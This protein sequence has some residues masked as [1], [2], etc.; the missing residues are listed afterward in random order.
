MADEITLDS[1]A[2][3]S[4]RE[5]SA[6]EEKKQEIAKITREVEKIT[7]VERER[8]DE[9]KKSI[10]LTD[11]QMSEQF[12]VGAQKN[13]AAFSE[14]ILGQIKSKDAGYVGD[15]LTNL[16]VTVKN[17]DIDEDDGNFFKKLPF[18]KQISN[19]AEKK[20][21][22]Y[23]TVE[24]QIDKIESE[25]DKARMGLLKDIGMLD[26]LYKQNVEYFNELQ[27]Y[28]L[29]GEEKIQELKTET[30]PR[31]REEAMKSDDA[32]STQ[33]VS[34]F[35][36]TVNRFEKKVHD[37][38]LSKTLAIQT[39]PQIK[40]IQNNDK[41]LVDKIQTAILNT[42]PLWK[43]QI[44]ISLA[45]DK[46]RAGV[47]MQ[48]SVSDTTNELLRK[49][50]EMLKSNTIE[51]AKE[52]ERGI[53]EI[54]TLKKVNDDLITTIDETLRI[55]KE[56]QARRLAAEQE[57]LKIEDTL[58]QSL[59]KSIDQG[60]TYERVQEPK[61]EG[62]RSYQNPVRD[63]NEDSHIESLLNKKVVDADIIEEE[64]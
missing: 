38:K 36:N 9:I 1:L 27:L 16:M 18:V 22:R 17:A 5:Q 44:V 11:S 64:K 28:I 25:L 41:A 6:Q 12:G 31:L 42:V 58:K 26:N 57:L 61:V 53:V 52:S 49:N 60:K 40:L 23:S 35:E 32:M 54:D 2:R 48:K 19:S 10:N 63:S 34:D 4:A 62:K 15:I 33:L 37:L 56:G 21:A 39:A 51:V 24:T 47:E 8:I 14:T 45:L 13:I 7:P 43:S 59:L 30:I 29:A 46:Q 3:S 55:Q 50:S 20:M